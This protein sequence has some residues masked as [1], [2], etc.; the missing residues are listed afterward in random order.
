MTSFYVESLTECKV[1]AQKKPQL[2]TF[3]LLYVRC[4]YSESIY[5]T[6]IANA[7]S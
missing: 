7:S 4:I 2:A 5:S 6:S 3:N 1:S